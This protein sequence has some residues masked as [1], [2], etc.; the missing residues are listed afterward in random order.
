MMHC[1]KN[2][3]LENYRHEKDDVNTK[4]FWKDLSI[5]TELQVNNDYAAPSTLFSYGRVQ[6][7]NI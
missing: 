1:S 7:I 4:L 5:Y 2:I 6:K 3:Y